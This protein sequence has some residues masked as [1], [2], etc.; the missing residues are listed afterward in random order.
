MKWTRLVRLASLA[1]AVSLASTAAFAY[2]NGPVRLVVPLS[3]GGATDNA[4]RIVAKG[5]SEALGQS[6]VV[7]N[8]P[9]ADGTIAAMS[10]VNAKPDGQTLFFSSTTAIC[11]VPT[12]RK[13]PPYD[14][15]TAF[16]PVSLVGTLEM[17]LLAHPSVE[18]KNLLEVIRYAKA[19]PEKTNFATSNS[20]ALLASVQLQ[21]GAGLQSVNVP[22]KGDAPA[23]V[24]LVAGRVH[25]MFAS[26]GAPM[27]YIQ[28]GRLRAV[29]ALSPSRITTL[30]DVPTMKEAGVEGMT[31][32][33]W[34][35]VL[36]PAGM[37]ADVVKRL[38]ADMAKVLANPETRA[39][40]IKF[41]VKAQA[42][43]S[44]GLGRFIREQI[45]AW[46]EAVRAAG[47]EPS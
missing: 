20:T 32:I 34:L 14:P 30:P 18:G 1:C 29:A 24:D 39:Q 12:M 11:A 16:T 5:L 13:N 47:I 26:P 31:I 7:E 8:K 25:L 21:R 22:Y 9:G 15:R 33:P 36:G 27:Q 10:V 6:V 3:P 17:V 45:G 37:P 4:A 38:S 46:D 41:G 35:G 44:A 19:N 2:P 43:D 28:E 42:T 23:L 40:L